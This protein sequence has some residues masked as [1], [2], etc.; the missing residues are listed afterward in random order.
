M[1]LSISAPTLDD[2]TRADENPIS[3]AGAWTA[4]NVFAADIDLKIVSNRI[5]AAGD[6]VSFTDASQ[7][8]NLT[9]GD[10]AVW[11]RVPT[12]PSDLIRLYGRIK[13]EGGAGTLDGYLMEY[14]ATSALMWRYT[15]GAATQL[16]STATVR[17]MTTNDV[18]ALVIIGSELYGIRVPASTGVPEL[19]IMRSDPT[20]TSGK[21]A[22]GTNSPAIRFS[23]L[24]GGA[25]QREADWSRFP[26]MAMA[27]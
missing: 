13:D 2:A 10:C 21:I 24:G 26:K 9:L 5:A 4:S 7:V 25:I 8:Y 11:A 1:A 15:N 14:S 20:W 27:R 19:A 12:S 3:N 23:A 18:I 6:G 16:G 17:A 22:L